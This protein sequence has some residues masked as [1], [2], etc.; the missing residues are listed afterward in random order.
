MSCIIMGAQVTQPQT[1]HANVISARIGHY[2]L[3]DSPLFVCEVYI[4]ENVEVTESMRW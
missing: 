3:D 1:F 4:Y 2:A